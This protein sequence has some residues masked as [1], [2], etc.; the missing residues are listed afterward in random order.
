LAAVLATVRT[1]CVKVKL[2]GVSLSMATLG[3]WVERDKIRAVE[4]TSPFPPD[5]CMQRLAQ[6]T[7]SRKGW[8]LDTRT[9]P[10]PYPLFHG[11]VEP[12]GVRICLFSEITARY[13][14]QNRVW[15]DVRV[16]PGLDGGTVLAGTAGSRTAP[17]NA[18]LSL[19]FTAVF[20]G[21]ALFS[22]VIGVV[23]TASGHFNFGVG[24]AIA[25]PVIVA[26]AI[27]T[28]RS[29]FTFKDEGRV[30]SFLRTVCGVLDAT[31]VCPD[32][33]FG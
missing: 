19:V 20:A 9:A 32:R 1:I 13:G 29:A 28:A 4:L 3:A 27:V 33:R 24:A 6:V 15:L 2:V 25:I 17:A 18:V 14:W 10:L 30:P 23:I 12:Q 11:T 8:Y 26:A 22:F 16:V 5:D 31:F 21:L 7:T